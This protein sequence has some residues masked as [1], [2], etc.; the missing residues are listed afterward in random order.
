[1]AQL[2][3][4]ACNAIKVRRASENIIRQAVNHP[5]DYIYYD[6][7]ELLT[8][9]TLTLYKSPSRG[10]INKV[11]SW[12]E[13]ADYTGY[14]YTFNI[15]PPA[16]KDF[17]LNKAQN[18][19]DSEGF[20]YYDT[21]LLADA[22]CDSTQYIY[23]TLFAVYEDG[24][25]AT[26]SFMGTYFEDINGKPLIYLFPYYPDIPRQKPTAL[27]IVETNFQ[28]RYPLKKPNSNK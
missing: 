10:Y 25:T 21:Y 6:L 12:N 27:E 9:E 20:Y 8:N 26:S 19:A 16:L 22:P 28:N 18:I 17:D 14:K 5:D 13:F 4:V 11:H 15:L 2:I 1:M 23:G 24:K 7:R 3:F